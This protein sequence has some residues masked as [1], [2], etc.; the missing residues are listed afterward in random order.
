MNYNTF[1]LTTPL[2]YLSG[3]LTQGY[4]YCYYLDNVQAYITWTLQDKNGNNLFSGSW[5]LDQKTFENWGQDNTVVTT[6]LLAAAPWSNP[7]PLPN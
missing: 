2:P 5:K 6:G 4:W 3:Q 1:I 7:L